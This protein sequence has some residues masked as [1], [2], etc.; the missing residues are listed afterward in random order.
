[1]THWQNKILAYR[2]Q[3]AEEAQSLSQIQ[4][5]IQSDGAAVL[6]RSRTAGHIT[7]SGFVMTP[8]LDAVLMVYH[9]IY[10][11]F[12]WT[13]GH[14]DGCDDLLGVALREV[15]EET[16]VQKAFPLT[17]A[18]LSV[19][20]L[21]V[22]PHQKHGKPVKAHMHYNITYGIIAN[23][24]EKLIIKPD[25]NSAV[26]W[27]PIDELSS[28]I[29]EPH[30]LPIY[31]KLIKRMQQCVQTQE[32]CLSQI[33]QPLLAWYPTHARDLPWRHTKEFYPVWLSEIML[34]QT[35]VE[36]VKGYYTRFLTQFPNVQS[37]ATADPE[38]VNKCW[39]GLGYYSRARN[40]QAAAKTIITKYG[41]N[42]PT[43]WAEVRSLPGV[44]DYTAGAICSICYGLPTPAVDGNVLRV[45]MRLTDC[46][47]EI[48][49]PP[50][51][52]AITAGLSRVYRENPTHCDTLTQALM[53]LG[54]TV[55][56]PNGTP[57]CSACPLQ[58]ICMAYQQEDMQLLPK[59]KEKK[60]HRFE[61]YT[62]FLL[63]C[64]DAYAVQ[65]RPETGLLAG[66][67]EFPNITGILTPEEAIQQVIEWNC[68]P[69]DVVQTMEKQ[70]IFT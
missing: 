24:K 15:R 6:N 42:F 46:F 16:G 61:Q 5:A 31:N 30:M 23:R 67:W 63:A 21:P 47:C 33:A 9:R 40:L 28:R 50:L 32:Q 11:S 41:T 1:M 12:S 70:H 65:K 59:R 36:A 35:R 51:K 43:T 26:A 39:E 68:Q 4:T 52:K 55:C 14:A 19:D 27:I 56:L 66:L 34:Q 25:E 20:V 64:D 8:E 62:V 44:G 22:P 18:I 2:P 7:C 10:R 29:S 38:A 49:R 60:K 45:M 54:A 3:S 37:L 58:K 48:D 53:E 57:Q 13:G 17:G 69:I